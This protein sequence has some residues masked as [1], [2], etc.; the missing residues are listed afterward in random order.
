VESLAQC[1]PRPKV[2]NGLAAIDGRRPAGLELGPRRGQR[3]NGSAKPRPAAPRSTGEERVCLDE[4]L[5]AMAVNHLAA[6]RSQRGML[7]RRRRCGNPA[8]VSPSPTGIEASTCWRPSGPSENG[9]PWTGLGSS[10]T[11]NG[12]GVFRH[13]SAAR[14][15][16]WLSVGGLI[17]GPGW[18]AGGPGAFA[19]PPWI[20]GDGR[21][22]QDLKARW[23]R[24]NGAPRSMPPGRGRRSHSVCG[25]PSP[26]RWP[27]HSDS[28]PSSSEARAYTSRKWALAQVE[29]NAVT[30]HGAA[31]DARYRRV[32]AA[33]LTKL[34]LWTKSR[35]VNVT[36]APPPTR[37]QQSEPRR[38]TRREGLPRPHF[39]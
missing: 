17:D 22:L 38:D 12:P 36:A 15:P 29:R 35:L 39:R 10:S 16:P 9:P 18:P 37:W 19:G 1:V 33:A 11:G 8:G 6:P 4:A 24:S 20:P 3:R 21:A 26:T 32:V 23:P 30:G 13:A 7:A 25:L 34:W 27:A 14:A 28:T 5:F 31:D 2:L